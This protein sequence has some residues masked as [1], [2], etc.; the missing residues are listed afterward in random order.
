MMY[1]TADGAG[2]SF[3]EVFCERRRC[4]LPF[5]RFFFFFYSI[6]L[7][8]LNITVAGEL[9]KLFPRIIRSLCIAVQKG[10]KL[11]LFA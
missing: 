11:L 1:R 2:A 3:F 7:F 8:R 4:T 10:R 6:D 9:R 5:R